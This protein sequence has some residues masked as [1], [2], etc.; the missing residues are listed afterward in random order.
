M[1]STNKKNLYFVHIPKNAGNSIRQACKKQ[2][3]KV[4]SH[5]IRKR[6]K[7]LL[8]AHRRKKDL[9]AFCIS[10]NPYDRI[11]SAYNYLMKEGK[12]KTKED[13]IERDEYLKP[14]ADFTDF[15]QNGL[16]H[17]AKNQLHFLPQVFWIKNH[18]GKPEVETVLK[19]ENLQDELNAFCNQMGFPPKKLD[20]TNT[21]HRKNTWE[22]YYT[23]ETKKIVAEI[24]H[25]DFEFF[26]YEK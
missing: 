1:F 24:Y 19:M 4:V 25:E 10:R 3:I 13:N 20:I 16:A 8:A 18:S 17:A 2:N 21:S 23:P 5:N 22:E 9:H 6:N 7:R 26:D 15:V 11:V 12:N 14:Y